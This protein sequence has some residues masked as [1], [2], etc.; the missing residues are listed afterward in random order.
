[1]PHRERLLAAYNDAVESERVLFDQVKGCGPGKP[2][3]NAKLFQM[4]LDALARTNEASQA[5]REGYADTVP[6]KDIH[7]PDHG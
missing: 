5:L 4:W 7:M 1:M 3:Y 2:G 6:P